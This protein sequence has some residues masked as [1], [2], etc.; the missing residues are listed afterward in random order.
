V[1]K[2]SDKSRRQCLYE[3]DELAIA[4]VKYLNQ[5]LGAAELPEE[6]ASKHEGLD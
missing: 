5:R 3:G 2:I 4:H 6:Q 1:S